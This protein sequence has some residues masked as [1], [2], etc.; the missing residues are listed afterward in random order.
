MKWN[1]KTPLKLETEQYILRSLSATDVNKKYIG[2]NRDPKVME[3][4]ELPMNI[5]PQQLKRYVQSFDNLNRFHLGI[6]CKKGGL[7]I[8]YFNIYC[9]GKNRN[10][11]T[12]VVIGDRDYWGKKVV[13][14]TRAKI[15]DFLFN[16]VGVHKV[17]GAI[18][19]RNLPSLFNYKAQGFTCEGVLRDQ[20]RAPDGTWRDVYRFGLMRD[21][22]LERNKAAKP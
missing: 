2:W 13:L 9:D 12:T 6:F 17:W 19:A 14:E 7:F 22:W 1:P 11:R 8:G 15:L 10:A 18:Y 16:V 20:D 5:P 4:V 3:N 21:E